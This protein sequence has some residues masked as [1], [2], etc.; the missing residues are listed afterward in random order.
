MQRT[1][2]IVSAAAGIGGSAHRWRHQRRR[3]H[4]LGV[5]IG[6]GGGSSAL[7]AI[8]GIIGIIGSA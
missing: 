6:G 8:G 4:Q 5:I 3:Q 2:G 1:R 7:N